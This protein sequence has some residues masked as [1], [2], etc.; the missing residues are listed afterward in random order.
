MEDNWDHK[1]HWYGMWRI[2]RITGMGC[3]G[4]GWDVEDPQDHWDGTQRIRRITGMG[5]GG[6]VGSLGWDVEDT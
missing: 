4:M 3:G 1:D 6:Y 2:R 5:C